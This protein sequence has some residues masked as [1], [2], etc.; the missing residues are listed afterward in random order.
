MVLRVWLVFGGLFMASV[1]VLFVSTTPVAAQQITVEGTVSLEDGSPVSGAKITALPSTAGRAVRN[2][3]TKKSGKFTLPFVE[4][5]T[6]RFR[7]AAEG[8]LMLSQDVRVLLPNKAEEFGNSG[9]IGPAQE[10]AE[11]EIGPGRTVVVKIVMVPSSHFAK[12][13]TIPGNKKATAWLEE[14]NQLTAEGEFAASDELLQKIVAGG[15]ESANVYYL[16]GRNASGLGKAAEATSYLEKSVEL[17]PEQPGAYSQ[18]A[19]LAFEAG[20]PAKALEL[21]DRELELN[22][23]ALPIMINRAIL[24]GQLARVD[25]AIAAFEAV[26]EVSPRE[27]AAYIEL[28]TLYMSKDDMVKAEELLN[29]MS[30]FAAPDP[31]LWFN[32]GANLSNVDRYDEA[33]AAYDK[34]LA[35][36]PEFG[37]A[38]REIGYLKIR[39]GD[40]QGAVDKFEQYLALSPDASD[41]DQV[42]SMRDAVAA[43]LSGG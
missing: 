6:Y 30:E 23:G 41:A 4:F 26:L 7:A 5:G 33:M 34:A 9:E 29:K 19:T 20:D 35:L 39:M 36:D 2:T 32:I 42:R 13:L 27:K 38:I 28:V 11:W 31:S 25:E 40:M 16:L 12:F 1:M 24:L 43:S 10:V 37:I 21:F 22:P 8:Y 18:L 14:A 17:N 15:D 3:K